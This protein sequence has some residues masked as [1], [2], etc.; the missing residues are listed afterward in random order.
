[1]KMLEDQLIE[2]RLIKTFKELVEIDSTSG[3]EEQIHSYLKKVIL[4]VSAEG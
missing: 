1:M 2:K 3:N 4:F